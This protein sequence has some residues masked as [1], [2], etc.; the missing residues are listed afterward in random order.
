MR[1]FLTG[2]GCVGKTTIGSILSSRLGYRFFDLDE[3]IERFFGTSIER[4]QNKFLTIHSYRN[5]AS[6]ALV[7]ILSQPNSQDCVIALP[8]SGLMG[9]FLRV[10]KKAAGMSVVLTDTPENIL[11]RI[12]FYDIDSRLIEKRL[13]QKEKHLYLREIKK[14][15]TYFRKT[16]DRADMEVDI[17]GLDAEYS[18]EKVERSIEAFLRKEHVPRTRKSEQSSPPDRRR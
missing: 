10:V 4:L 13:T 2:I 18:A 8:P 9:G 6:T 15:I 7:H 3:E 12:T 5:E 17:S 11:N 1:I 16:Y 14:D